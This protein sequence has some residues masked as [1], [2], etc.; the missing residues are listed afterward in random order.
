VISVASND[1]TGNRAFYSNFGTRIDVTAPGGEV[2]LETDPPGTRSTPQ[3]GILSTLNTGTT[4]QAQETYV[5]Y[6]GTSM[7][8]PHTAGLVALMLSKTP[9]S[10]AQV[11]AALKANARPLPGTC[12]GG[13]G[14]GIIDAARTVGA[15]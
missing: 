10:P 2:R 11:E 4:V 8:A 7:A 12:P 9:L 5:T 15:I 3:N 1:R 6:M 13:C 14:A